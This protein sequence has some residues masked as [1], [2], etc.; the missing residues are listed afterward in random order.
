V[1]SAEIL[2]PAGLQLQAE[3]ARFFEALNSY[4]AKGAENPRLTFQQ[5]LYRFL[6]DDESV[7]ADTDDSKRRSGGH[8]TM[9]RAIGSRA[10]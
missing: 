8:S 2:A 6:V 1:E 4:P 9:R 10:G 5:H 7:I 3:V